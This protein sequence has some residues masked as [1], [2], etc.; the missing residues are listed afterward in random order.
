M[1][2]PKMAKALGYI[3]D[4][5][6]SGAIEYKREKK[7]N[8]WVKWGAMA[9]C[10]CLVVAGAFGGVYS[11]M[12]QYVINNN[13]PVYYAGEFND[14][15]SPSDLTSEQAD[16]LAKAND[17]HN[18]L[19]AQGYGWY[20]SCYYDFETG[21]IMVGLTDVSDS[22]RNTVLT[23]IGDVSVQFYQC[24]YSYQYLEELYNKLDGK[25][26]ALSVLGVDRFNISIEKNRVNV[27][28]N[29]AEKYEAIYMANEMDSLGGAIVFTSDIVASDSK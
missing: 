27:H 10:L 4:D 25:R 9:A 20:G 29:N 28:I 12:K 1:S 23:H 7:K 24:G 26:V 13:I 22:N 16:H 17:I 11:H 6:V 8:T 18:T 5:L 19:S 21:A 14:S 15:L 3:D 2:I